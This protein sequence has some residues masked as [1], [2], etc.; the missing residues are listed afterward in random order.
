LGWPPAATTHR[1]RSPSTA[2]W[3][4][5]VPARNLGVTASRLSGHSAPGRT[6]RL[7]DRT[8]KAGE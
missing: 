5:S 6:P 1:R 4:A 8:D 3:L 7:A 2:C